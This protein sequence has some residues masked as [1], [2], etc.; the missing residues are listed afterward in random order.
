MQSGRYVH[1]LGLRDQ[2]VGILGQPPKGAGM[3]FAELNHRQAQIL[4]RRARDGEDD[5]GSGSSQ[6]AR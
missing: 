1:P 4:I 5:V 2:D 3:R 6:L